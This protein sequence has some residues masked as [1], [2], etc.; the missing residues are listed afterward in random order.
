M[1][2]QQQQQ[3]DCRDELERQRRADVQVQM[4]NTMMQTMMMAMLANSGVPMGGFMQSLSGIQA[5]AAAGD[6]ARMTARECN[7]ARQS[8]RER[9]SER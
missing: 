2:R 7:E 4:Q 9:G 1:M 8:Q 5:A 3:Q 6:G